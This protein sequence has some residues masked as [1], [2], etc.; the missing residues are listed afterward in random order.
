MQKTISKK[1]IESFSD[2]LFITDY[3]R[4]GQG[5]LSYMLCH[6]CGARYI[7][8]YD[9]ANGNKFTNSKKLSDLLLKA[10]KRKKTKFS[11]VLK[12]HTKFVPLK[13]QLLSDNI[14]HLTRDPRDVALSARYLYK[15]NVY[16]ASRNIFSIIKNLPLIG[17]IIT[18]LGWRKHSKNWLTKSKVLNVRYED[19]KKEPQKALTTI[20][21]YFK[22]SFS[23]S[24]LKECID[25]YSFESLYNRKPGVEDKNNPESRKGISGDS[26]KKFNYFEKRIIWFITGSTAEKFGY[27][28]DYSHLNYS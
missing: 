1:K 6:M 12:S 7:E 28:W 26:K 5:W 4:S 21:K 14:I 24:E 23:K 25:L 22:I 8:P 10:Q 11:I 15:K 9:F 16:K 13:D 19:L 17:L 2:I 20:L 18:S 27:K 3:G